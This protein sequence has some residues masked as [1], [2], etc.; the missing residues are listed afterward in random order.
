MK[1]TVTN[2]TWI[3]VQLDTQAF[4]CSICLDFLKEP[5]TLPCGHNY[6]RSCIQS[7][8]DGQE[9]SS[10][11]QCRQSFHPRPVLGTN[12]M[13]AELVEKLQRVELQQSL[14]DLMLETDASS[15]KTQT[16]RWILRIIQDK[17]TALQKLQQEALSF[18]R[19]ADEVV[20]SSDQSFIGLLRELRFVHSEVSREIKALQEKE[21]AKLKQVHDNLQR[22][23]T[24][25]RMTVSELDSLTP[26][27][28]LQHCPPLSA[29]DPPGPTHCLWAPWSR[30][31]QL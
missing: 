25:M 21:E 31:P 18:R 6:C 19:S 23:I 1:R 27:Q 9:Q 20:K 30:R 5:A 28:T 29:L 3:S 17:E 22:D 13:L 7:Y 8:W 16:K 15:K 10:C 14:K 11:P 4:S 24:L 2:F 12:T 26:G